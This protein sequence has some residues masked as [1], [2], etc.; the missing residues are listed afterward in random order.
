M[1][2]VSIPILLAV[3]GMLIVVLAL[4]VVARQLVVSR[5]RRAFECSIHRRSLVGGSSWQHGLM[6]LGTDRLRWLRASSMPPRPE[7]VLRRSVIGGASRRS[8]VGGSSW[9]H[10]L[11]RFGTDRLRWFRASSMRLR[12]EGV[13]RR[14]EIREVSRRRL[15][16]QLPE[17]E[18]CYLVTFEL[19]GGRTLEAIVDLPSGAALNA[20]LEAAPTGLVRGDAD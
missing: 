4:A 13:L 6:R 3:I 7:V 11:M 12:P 1:T 17:G 16:A 20:W 8:L 2:D 10:G 14:S 18:D 15:A 5:Q 19:Q 9:Q